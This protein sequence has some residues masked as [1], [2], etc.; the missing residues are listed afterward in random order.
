MTSSRH[1]GFLPLHRGGL[2]VCGEPGDFAA[3]VWL[4]KQASVIGWGE[5]FE[6]TNSD[7]CR[8]SGKGKGWVRGYLKKLVAGGALVVVSKGDRQTPR[9][10]SMVDPFPPPTNDQPNA[11]VIHDPD[12]DADQKADQD[13]DHHKF[14]ESANA[15]GNDSQ[16]GP[17]G[18]SQ[19]GPVRRQ[20]G[21]LEEEA[22]RE[23]KSVDG[24]PSSDPPVDGSMEQ[25]DEPC[26]PGL[27]PPTIGTEAPGSRAK[28]VKGAHASVPTWAQS[29]TLGEADEALLTKHEGAVFTVWKVL[30]LR[31]PT[32]VNPEKADAIATARALEQQPVAMLIDIICW[33]WDTRHCPHDAGLR[34]PWSLFRLDGSPTNLD[35]NV[36]RVRSAMN[37][38]PKPGSVAAR[39]P[40]PAE[41]EPDF[42]APDDPAAQWLW[43][44]GRGIT[45]VDE[46]CLMTGLSHPPRP[47]A[48]PS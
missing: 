43:L 27:K 15:A 2:T 20:L 26:E 19:T 4:S 17:A 35:H 42:E 37:P 13:A 41:S 48:R 10:V 38:P 9:E 24:G 36:A 12:Q 16:P 14:D 33:A 40:H 28:G 11:K 6:A 7:L 18:D 23:E 1:L 5:P 8:A 3:L 47:E 25:E 32:L 30:Q 39:Q 29:W 46:L 21:D 45:D 44:Q 31:W 34:R 22:E